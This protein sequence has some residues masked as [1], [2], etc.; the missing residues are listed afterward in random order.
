MPKQTPESLEFEHRE[1]RDALQRA[2]AAPGKT[3]EAA[4]EVF[5]VLSPHILLEQE[6]A[7]PPLTQIARIAR[8]D[9]T[10]DMARFIDKTDAFKAELPRMLDEH[11]LIVAALRTLMQAAAA[12]KQPGAAQF[13]QKM[14]QH[15]Q[16]E[17]EILYPAAIL[18][19]EY[20]R[21]KMGR[22][23]DR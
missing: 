8:G 15:A 7:M 11:K 12:E 14:I 19:G 2:A 10:P 1:L 13:A 18:V 16:M 6:F 23:E 5:K 3:G 4:R 20:L 17:E 9:I 21:L 22:V